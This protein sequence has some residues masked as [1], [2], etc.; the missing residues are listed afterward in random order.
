M[1]T[2]TVD[3]STNRETRRHPELMTKSQVAEF[4]QCS[5]RQ[6]ELLTKAGRIPAPVYLSGQ[7]PRWRRDEL[8][9]ALGLNAAE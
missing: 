5:K 6:I 4:C 2:T 9:E 7:S 8:F 1:A 3:A